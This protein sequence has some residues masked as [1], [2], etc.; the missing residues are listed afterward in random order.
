MGPFKPRRVCLSQSHRNSGSARIKEPRTKGTLW[1]PLTICSHTTWR[2][3]HHLPKSLFH[4]PADLTPESPSLWDPGVR[5]PIESPL[6]LTGLVLRAASHPP[7]AWPLPSKVWS[8]Q[9][10]LCSSC[11]VFRKAGVMASCE[12]KRAHS[13]V[14]CR[15]TSERR[16]FILSY[17]L[18]EVIFILENQKTKQSIPPKPLCSL[19]TFKWLQQIH[20][21][22]TCHS[23][24]LMGCP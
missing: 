13:H 7:L 3:A 16:T 9:M 8:P 4:L 1:L 5:L 24:A 20:R 17:V 19:S 15:D 23:P 6:P 10:S 11:W 12:L 22:P 14:K 18:E 2:G 21:G